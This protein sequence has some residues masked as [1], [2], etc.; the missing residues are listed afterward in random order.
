MFYRELAVWTEVRIRPAV[1]VTASVDSYVMQCQCCFF[2]TIFRPGLHRV[3]QLGPFKT[4][5]KHPTWVAG[6]AFTRHFQ[7]QAHSSHVLGVFIG[8]SNVNTLSI[9]II[10][11]QTKY[12][13]SKSPGP[14]IKN[15]LR[16]QSSQNKENT[17]THLNLRIE[18]NTET[19][20]LSIQ[21]IG[22]RLKPFAQPHSSCPPQ[23][24]A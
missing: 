5:R 4:W 24:I 19:T 3:R 1:P 6:R 11:K 16:D 17:N 22:V 15:L 18:F 10:N 8:V 2:K 21:L 7:P 20:Y 23:V 9:D 14:H 13:Q 12:Y